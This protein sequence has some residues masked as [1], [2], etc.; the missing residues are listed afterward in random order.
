MSATAKGG[1]ARV[2]VHGFPS[3]V[4]SSLPLPRVW[5]PLET[6]LQVRGNLESR[7]ERPFGSEPMTQ[8]LP[9]VADK[10]RVVF[11]H[12]R[13]QTKDLAKLLPL[14]DLYRRAFRGEFSVGTGRRIRGSLGLPAGGPWLCRLFWCPV[15]SPPPLTH[16][17]SLQDPQ[18]FP[19]I[20]V[21]NCPGKLLKQDSWTLSFNTE[22][23]APLPPLIGQ[24][25]PGD[26]ILP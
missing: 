21:L 8:P 18:W 24:A 17:T 22:V 20:Q 10:Q 13:L 14:H 11:E 5:V 3:E 12:V 6:L 15:C 7:T 19:Q 4:L 26:L 23:C 25:P 2:R 16:T 9:A 1:L